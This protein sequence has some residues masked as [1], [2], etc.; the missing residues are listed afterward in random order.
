MGRDVVIKRSKV[1]E[2][3][4]R[5]GATQ[6]TVVVGVLGQKGDEQHK[7]SPPGT[8]VAQVAQWNHFGTGTIP[9]RPFLTIAMDR[10]K[11]EI[12]RIQRRLAQG[13]LEEKLTLDQALGLLG[14]TAVGFVKQTI[15]DGVPPP[16]AESTAISKGSSTPLINFGQLR[17]SVT[18][19]VREGGG[20]PE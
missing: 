3:L 17:G 8:T 6:K 9:A 18:Y 16:N 14:E 4:R 12:Q 20:T 5:L 15:A 13:L 2:T 1:F 7:D 11:P 19:A 10:H